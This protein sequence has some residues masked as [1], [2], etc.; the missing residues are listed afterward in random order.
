MQIQSKNHV[1]SSAVI[2]SS[3]CNLQLGFFL[4]AKLAEIVHEEEKQETVES[5]WRYYHYP[6]YY[7]SAFVT[8]FDLYS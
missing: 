7:R 5:N 3:T 6:L 2:F 4:Q 1:L 8:V